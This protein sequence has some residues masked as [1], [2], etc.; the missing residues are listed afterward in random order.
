VSIYGTNFTGTNWVSFGGVAAPSV[1]VNSPTKITVVT[2]EHT[3]AVVHVRVN[4]PLGTSAVTNADLYAYE[5]APTITSI[6]PSSGP[7]AGGQSVV[8]TG[9]NLFGA[10]WVSFG[11]TAAASFTVNSP[12]QITA[13][14]P[15]HG[16][17][18]VHVRVNT[19]LGTSAATAAD[20]YAYDNFGDPGF[21]SG[22]LSHWTIDSSNP[23]PAVTNA[24][25]HT[26]IYSAHL[27]S[28]PLNEV[29]GDSSIFQQVTMPAGSS[30]LSFWYWPR[31]EDSV[32]YDW[33]DVY[34]TNTSG[35]ILATVMHVCRNDQAW[36]HVTFDMSPYAGQTVRVKF[37]VHGDTFNDA[38]DMFVDDVSVTP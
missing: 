2:P 33:Q 30:H 8:I 3:V 5:S 15:A 36:I 20:V 6:S 29:A 34:V 1:T 37:L 38:T 35:T 25:A 16:A 24:N 13:T 4:T 12:T 17:G 18:Y 19:P 26:G 9:T 7:D 23:E 11:S 10:N 27:G 14:S 32:L 31:T 28:L 21:E 22:G